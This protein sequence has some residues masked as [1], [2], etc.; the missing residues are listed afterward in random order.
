MQPMEY[1]GSS[2]YLGEVAQI[3]MPTIQVIQDH[4]FL[5]QDTLSELYLKML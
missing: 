4:I 3:I 1:M 5:L 2:L